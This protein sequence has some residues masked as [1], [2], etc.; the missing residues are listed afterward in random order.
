MFHLEDHGIVRYPLQDRHYGFLAMDWNH[1]R[2]PRQL[3]SGCAEVH[4]I[5]FINLPEIFTFGS[6]L[7]FKE[8]I[9]NFKRDE[10]AG[11]DY[12]RPLSDT[13]LGSGVSLRRNPAQL[14]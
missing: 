14:R 1:D 4:P 5:I 3:S 11:K 2:H 6:V 7:R 9:N 13:L 8:R 12:K 10:A